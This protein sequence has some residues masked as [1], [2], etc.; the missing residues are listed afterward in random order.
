MNALRSTTMK[1][2]GR[3]EKLI[4]VVCEAWRSTDGVKN[5]CGDD[6][7]GL[8]TPFIPLRW[9]DMARQGIGSVDDSHA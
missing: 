9:W 4:G 5:G 6:R 8:Q 1:G 7:L 3:S 2:S